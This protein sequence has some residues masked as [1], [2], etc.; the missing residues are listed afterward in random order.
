MHVNVTLDLLEVDKTAQVN[1]IS[2]QQY[3]EKSCMTRSTTAPHHSA[4]FQE[5]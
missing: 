5:N 4:T 3:L 2:L 1:L